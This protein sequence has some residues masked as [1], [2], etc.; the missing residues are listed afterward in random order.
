MEIRDPESRLISVILAPPRP[1]RPHQLQ[2]PVDA[3][4]KVLT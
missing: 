1:L 4:V 2:A 3:M